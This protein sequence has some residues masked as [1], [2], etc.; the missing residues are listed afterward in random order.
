MAATFNESQKIDYLW[1]KIGYG[2]TKTAESTVKEAVNES[3]PSPLLYRGDLVWMQSGDIPSSPP[4]STSSIIRVYKDGGGAG[5][6][7]TVECT[8]DLTSPDNQTWKTNLT[9]WI[10]TQFGD[11]YLVLVYVANSGVNN[12]QTVGTKLFA[13]GSGSDDTW[14]FDYQAGVLNFNGSTI[15]TQ[16]ASP[17][18]GKSIYIVGYRYIG[19]QG[20]TNIPS[21]TNIGNLNLT[22]TTISSID[23]NGNIILTP[24]GTGI[25]QISS[26]LTANGNITAPFFIG[27]G[28]QLTGVS[29]SNALSAG[30][31]T[32]NAQPN[33]TSVGTLTS[34]T[35][36]GNI[37]TG[38]ILTDNYYYANGSPLDFQQPSGSNTQIQFNDN[39]NFG[40]SANFTFNSSTN[41]LTVTGNIAGSNVNAGNLLTANYISG[42]L[43][44]AAQPNITSTGTLGSLN[45]TGNANVG[46]IGA[47]AGV[48]TSVTG[49]LTTNA[50]SNVT[51]VGT[52]I[53]LAVTGNASAGNIL[54]DNLLYANGS[55]WDMQLPQ[56]S[57]TS[58]QFNDDSSFGGSANF[59][60]NKSTNVLTVTGNISGSNV[61][62]GN[63]L[64][65]NYVAGTLTTNAQPNIT[66]TGTLV[67]LD[68]TGNLSAGNVNAGNLLTANYLTGTL[69]TNAQPNITSTGTLTSLSVTGNLSAG[70]V[71]AGNLLTA[72][73]LTGTLTT[74][75]QPNITSTGTLVSLDVTGNLSAGNL[76]INGSGSFD[77]NVNM[78]T[79][80]ITNL[81]NP[82][83][84]QDAA[85]K[86]YVDSTAQGLDPKASVNV[87][88][89]VP[90]GTYSYN[91]GTSGV[92]ATIT[93]SSIGVLTIDTIAVKLNNRVLVKNEPSAGAFN[94]YN[95]IYLCTTEGTAS[96]AYVLTRSTDFNQ[97]SEMYSAYTF[98]EEGYVNADTGWV[99]TNNSSTPIIIG[100]TPIVFT[101]FS[102]AGTYTAGAGLTLTGTE[103]SV[104][105]AQPGITSVGTL[106]SLNVTGNAN[107]GNIGATSGIFTNVTGTLTTNAQ[108]NVTSVGTLTS[109]NVTGN[110]NVGNIG[111]TAGVF[112]SVTGTLT[113][114]AQPNVTSVGTLTSLNVTGNANV[115]N[116]GAT[117]GVFTS[118][119]GTLTTNAQPNITSTGT[120]V[121]LTVTGNVAAGNIL[122]DNLLYANGSPWDM[123][124]PQGSNTSVQ[125]NDDSS[126][127]GSANFTFNKS[128]N[129]L[130]V[131]GNIAGSN[132]NAGNLLTANYVAGTLTTNAQPNITST[133]T[134]T[135]LTVSGVSNV[136]PVG[137][138]TVT[139]GTSG[140]YLQTN[141]SGVL[142]WGTVGTSGIANGTSN[143]SIPVINGNVN[144]SVGGNANVLVVTDTGI[145]VVG[146]VITGNGGGGNITGANLVSANYFTGTL[147]TN[148]QPNITSVGTLTSLDI[149]GKLTANTFQ[150][151]YGIYEFYTAYV[152]YATTVSTAA[153]QVLW[154]KPA[155]GLSAVDFTIIGTDT[156][157]ATR[158]TLKIS[159]AI[160]GTAVAYNEYGGLYINGGVGSFSVGYNPNPGGPAPT[161][162]L[163][164]TPD[165]SNLTE[166][167]MM[168]SEYAV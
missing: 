146:T 101:Q 97:A 166:Y 5:Y 54:T 92:G 110:A 137:N 114:N 51:S 95:G 37:T 163:I 14:F 22:G 82:V 120:L 90:L 77:G 36:A 102:G 71:N 145:N 149:S 165:S 140:Q 46:N 2:V 134:L 40:A 112:T 44:T 4:S 142:S 41:V 13:A 93:G 154:S 98:T 151:G 72:N 35:V 81:A 119:T 116:I 52:L 147:T 29:A 28:S 66:S 68:V 15:P 69:T 33:I 85:T 25:I 128:T 57:N 99:C 80:S 150:M 56:G 143:I 115:G 47:T 21:N 62:A 106:T 12:P 24:N 161:F 130:T 160:L 118:V 20:V 100:T 148:A 19:L 129:V 125:F 79:H 105:T 89:T 111:A 31:V 107:V 96:A 65:A 126:F 78:N 32:T 155:A 70:N 167:R 109:L 55:P 83:N 124:Q 3:I 152:F 59:T 86:Y 132:V 74:N 122:T 6:S 60:F 38:G 10:P 113:T 103:F 30:T 139:G 123:Q 48:F 17:I 84:D 64:T 135:S 43:T 67:S 7:A 39:Q 16:I 157:G 144:T 141:G 104:N 88:T 58:V 94:A 11:N 121:S 131:T 136:G 61:N 168:I 1:K 133:G 75:A 45:V 42:T 73:Y 91:N 162:D 159:A 53:S 117:A 50:Q 27:N 108:P 26:A 164:V 76:T 138:L 34:L 87:S 158:Q 23:T 156:A 9:G 18:T 127:G 153:G 63:L 49:T 8:E